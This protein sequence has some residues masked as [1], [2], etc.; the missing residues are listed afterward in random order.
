MGGCIVQTLALKYREVIDKMVISNSL[1]KL[2]H[3]TTYAQQFLYELRQ[4][5]CAMEKLAK[6]IMPWLFSNQFLANERNVQNFIKQ[7][8]F[9]P[10]NLVG[11]KRQMH[12]L[13]QFDSHNWIKT[14]RGPALIIGCDEDILCPRESEL[15]ANQIYEAKFVEFHRVGHCPMIEK[16]KEFVGIITNYLK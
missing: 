1:I 3:I 4:E 16:P 8:V 12:A 7:Q 15:L 11:F 2:N 13:L 5:G 6:G 9:N 14:I 10:Q